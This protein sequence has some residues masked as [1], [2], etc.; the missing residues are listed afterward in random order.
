MSVV[1]N[2]EG[3]NVYDFLYELSLWW[4]GFPKVL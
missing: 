4:G 2:L 3:F 1:F